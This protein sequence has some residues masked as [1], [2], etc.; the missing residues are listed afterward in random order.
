M[1]VAADEE[2][3]VVATAEA[4]EEAVVDGNPVFPH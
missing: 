2:V 4:A 1:V 3:A